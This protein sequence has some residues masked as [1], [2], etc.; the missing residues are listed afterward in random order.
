MSVLMSQNLKIVCYE[1]K[2]TKEE[3]MDNAVYIRPS[4]YES[5]YK[6]GWIFEKFPFGG[7]IINEVK[8]RIDFLE[9]NNKVFVGWMATSI[10]E[11][12][13]YYIFYKQTK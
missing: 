12:H 10:R 9:K 8:K 13:N 11:Y 7:G 2:M 1:T 5:L 6:N 3:I 4:R